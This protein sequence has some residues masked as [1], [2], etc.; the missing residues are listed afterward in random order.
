MSEARPIVV[1]CGAEGATD[2]LGRALA[3]VLT[4]GV[5]VGLAGPLGAGKTR[6]VR[7][8]AAGLG[9]DPRDVSSPTFVLIHEYEGDLPVFH[10]DAYRLDTPSQFEALGVADYWEAGGVCLVEWADRVADLLPPGAWWVVAAIDEPGRHHYELRVPSEVA[11]RLGARLAD[12]ATLPG[13]NLSV[14]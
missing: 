13:R 4:P 3:E 9:V 11:E 14:D 6:L 10:F 8:I 7:A 5:V 1:R 12:V 2:A